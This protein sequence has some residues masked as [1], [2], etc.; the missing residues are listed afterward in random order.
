MKISVV[1]IPKVIFRLLLESVRSKK[2]KKR[3][4]NRSIFFFH[5]LFSLEAT[6]VNLSSE[7]RGKK[8]EFIMHF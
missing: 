1:F 5:V 8:E 7:K 6:I 2:K 3:K 4:K